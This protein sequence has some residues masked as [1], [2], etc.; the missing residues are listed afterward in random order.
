MV[1]MAKPLRHRVP[2][3]VSFGLVLN[4]AQ[5]GL[6]NQY[7]TR[8]NPPENEHECASGPDPLPPPPP[9]HC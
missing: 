8:H 1:F 5:M 4:Y 6:S 3:Y 9:A 7:T 2:F